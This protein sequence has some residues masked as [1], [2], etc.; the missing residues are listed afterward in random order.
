MQLS[1]KIQLHFS[2]LLF[3][4]SL[5]FLC[6]FYVVSFAQVF[7]EINLGDQEPLFMQ[8]YYFVSYFWVY[9]FCLIALLIALIFAFG[10]K[11]WFLTTWTPKALVIKCACTIG[12][13]PGYCLETKSSFYQKRNMQ[14]IL[15]AW[16]LIGL[17]K[18][19]EIDIR[20]W[21]LRD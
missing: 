2:K 7:P 3:S 1:Q 8:K 20:G 6:M 4:L 12:Y 19:P 18:N 10:Y 11:Q 14:H 21:N 17:N 15:V 13:I 16:I 9:G 5:F